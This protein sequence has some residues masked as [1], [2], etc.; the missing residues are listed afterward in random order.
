IRLNRPNASLPMVLTNRF[1]CVV[2]RDTF[3]RPEA[4]ARLSQQSVGTG[5]F[6]LAEFRPNSHIRLARNPK[7]WQP[8]L[9]YLDG[10]LFSVQPNAASLLV[11]LRN[12]RADLALLA[13]PQDAEQLRDVQGM[14]IASAPSL[15]Q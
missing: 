15:R 6:R 11:A 4:R 1:G 7:Y 8:G 2:P 5:P 14:S 12:R 3:A 10:V 13:R 9:P